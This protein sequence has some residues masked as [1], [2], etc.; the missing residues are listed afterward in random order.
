MAMQSPKRISLENAHGA[1]STEKSK[2]IIEKIK[3]DGL[4]TNIFDKHLPLISEVV[5]SPLM[6]GNKVDLL[7]SYMN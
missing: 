1:I 7:C 5:G 4:E 3:R 2:K 6:V